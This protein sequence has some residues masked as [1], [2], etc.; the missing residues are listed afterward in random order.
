MRGGE[1]NAQRLAGAI[2]RADGPITDFY[3]LAAV[4]L[5][6]RTTL[7]KQPFG[8]SRQS[9]HARGGMTIAVYRT[10]TENGV[11]KQPE[12]FQTTF[13]AWPNIYVFNPADIGP[14]G[15]P[16]IP[17]GAQPAPQMI[18]LRAV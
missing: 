1:R 10:I 8:T 2:R 13:R 16:L 18:W 11:R 17:F 15:K 6:T 5:K 3:L 4:D 14:D 7:W 9:D 12:L